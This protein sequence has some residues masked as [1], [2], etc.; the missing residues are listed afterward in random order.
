MGLG[1]SEGKL[2]DESLKPGGEKRLLLEFFFFFLSNTLKWTF[3]D[4][5]KLYIK[6]LFINTHIFFVKRNR[7]LSPGEFHKEATTKTKHAYSCFFA[8]FKM[9]RACVVAV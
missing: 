4:H 3:A 7:L 6:L 2:Q 9:S 8:A 5:N 1:S